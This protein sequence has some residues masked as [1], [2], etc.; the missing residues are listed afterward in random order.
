MPK[1]FIRKFLPDPHTI[2][3]NRSLKIFGNLLQDPN[4]W[5]LNR[6]SVSAAFAVG[7]FFAWIPVPF[8]M[9]LAA[10]MA[11]FVRSN[12]PISVALVWLSNPITMPPLFYFAYKLGTWILN[13]PETDFSF[14]LSFDWLMNGMLAIWQPFLT[15]CFTMAVLSSVLGFVGMRLAW[16]LSI[17]RYINKKKLSKQKEEHS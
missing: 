16:R 9:A 7:L 12:L 13:T 11:I 15:G 17:V 4:L 6:K 10:G 5:H 8:Q 1:K 3:D 14:E 2:R